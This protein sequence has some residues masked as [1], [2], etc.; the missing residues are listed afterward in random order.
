VP[1][2]SAFI[3]CCLYDRKLGGEGLVSEWNSKEKAGMSG[4]CIPKPLFSVVKAM[5]G[6]WALCERL[7]GVHENS[8]SIR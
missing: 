2:L 5:P 3:N 4:R 8:V 1:N 7:D 6:A